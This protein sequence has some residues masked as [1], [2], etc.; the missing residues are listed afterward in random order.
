MKKKLRRGRRVKMPE[1]KKNDIG[2]LDLPVNG[3]GFI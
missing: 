2:G 3:K 1:G